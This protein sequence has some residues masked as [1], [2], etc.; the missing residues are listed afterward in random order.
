MRW[1]TTIVLLV[2][3]GLGGIAPRAS[4]QQPVEVARFS[5]H[6]GD[7]YRLVLSQDRTLLATGG[8][9]KLAFVLEARTLKRL[10]KYGPHAGEVRGVA[11]L[12]DKDLIVG[13]L[14]GQAASSVVRWSWEAAEDQ[15]PQELKMGDTS[16]FDFHVALDERWM[17]GLTS[18]E[19]VAMVPLPER[20]ERH[21]LAPRDPDQKCKAILFL[22]REKQFLIGRGG[23]MA[24][25]QA[26]EQ[27][28]GLTFLYGENES[29]VT[30]IGAMR[31]PDRIV[32]CHSDGMLRIWSFATERPIQ[33][34]RGHAGE[35][36]ALAVSPD[37][38]FAATGGDDKLIRIWDL[39]SRAKVREIAGHTGRVHALV[40]VSDTLLASS[41]QDGTVR[42]WSLDGKA[43]PN[44]SPPSV[45]PTTPSPAPVARRERLPLPPADEIAEAVK[46]TQSVFAEE[47]AKAKR[48]SEK[49]KLIEK[50]IAQADD[51]KAAAADRYALLQEAFRLAADGGQTQ[52]AL[53]SADQLVAAFV[54]PSTFRQATATRLGEVATTPKDQADAA[55]LVLRW[56]EELRLAERFDE[57]DVL[58]KTA[59]RTAVKSRSTE[60]IDQAK[61]LLA[62]VQAER[63]RWTGFQEA[64]LALTKN[65]N[66]PL[67]RVA[68][69]RYLCFSKGDWKSGMTHLAKGPDGPLK[70][71]AT[72]EAAAMP[73]GIALAEAWL[74]AAAHLPPADLPYCQAAALYWYEQALPTAT[75]LQKL[76]AQQEMKKLGTPG[77]VRK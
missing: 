20:K 42:L 67:P 40:Y 64:T 59:G 13:T 27:V 9:D 2:G 35:A 5:E 1:L 47:Y 37:G 15:E 7:V 21:N 18:G 72:K 76:R 63:E 51:E 10:K 33:K 25:W 61:A 14:R 70:E 49:E 41:S 75:G 60:T 3:L 36:T 43:K 74:A 30:G 77:V 44:A 55:K 12:R 69:G 4:G 34:F 16:M 32:T 62:R 66:D 52:L 31:D 53:K 38:N 45:V 58:T 57:A 50:L 39:A 54:L 73:D 68:I 22:P 11:I 19:T 46:L 71:L 48:P 28:R 26:G 56:A 24:L 8:K 17:A 23:G 29:V 6:A 65:V